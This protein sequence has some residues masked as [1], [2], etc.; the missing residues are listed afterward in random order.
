MA[1]L[2]NKIQTPFEVEDMDTCTPAS[3]TSTM[4]KLTFQL[5]DC[6]IFLQGAVRVIW[7]GA[8]LVVS[9]PNVGRRVQCLQCGNIGHTIAR[10]IFSDAQLRGLGAIVAAEQDIAGLGDIARPFASLQELRDTVRA[11]ITDHRSA[12]VSS[13]TPGQ[14]TVAPPAP[15]GLRDSARDPQRNPKPVDRE[16][17]IL[18]PDEELQPVPKDPQPWITHRA[19]KKRNVKV[20]AE[21]SPTPIGLGKEQVPVGKIWEKI[22]TWRPESKSHLPRRIVLVSLVAFLEKRLLR[23][24]RFFLRLRS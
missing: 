5:S 22:G 15:T 24:S 23:S 8:I 3:R 2:Q 10:C 6:P 9:H 16:E 11:R 21:K 19:T 17:G 14:P 12:S 13:S 18:P 7:F 4:W 1:F 20:R